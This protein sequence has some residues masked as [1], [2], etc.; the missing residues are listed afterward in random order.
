MKYVRQLRLEDKSSDGTTKRP[1]SSAGSTVTSATEP[2]EPAAAAGKRHKIQ[3]IGAR[4]TWGTLSECTVNSVKNVI[5]RICKLENGLHVR[6]KTKFSPVT[7]KT[8]WWFVVH[9]DG[10]NFQ[11]V[12]NLTWSHL[13]FSSDS[14]PSSVTMFHVF[15]L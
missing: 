11:D 4:R 8:K 12:C 7:N 9:T 13:V 1:E 10:S 2:N 3:V 14:K 6:C 5:S 15:R